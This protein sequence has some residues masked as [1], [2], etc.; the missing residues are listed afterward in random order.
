MSQPA[1]R[2]LPE[3]LTGFLRPAFL[4]RLVV[5]YIAVAALLMVCAP[6]LGAVVARGARNLILLTSA[7]P[8]LDTLTWTENH[9]RATTHLLGGHLSIDPQSLWFV[10][11]FPTG[12]AAA[13]PGLLSV[14][15]LARLLATIGI[16]AAVASFLLAITMDGLISAK[17]HSV[18]VQ[19]NPGWRDMLVRSAMGRFWD[20]AALMYPFLACLALAW[21]AVGRTLDPGGDS[22]LHWSNIAGVLALVLLLFAADRHAEELRVDNEVRLRPLLADLNPYYG[23]HLMMRAAKLERSGN[24]HVAAEACRA[25]KAYPRFEPEARACLGRIRAKL[26]KLEAGH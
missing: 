15:G 13:L 10:V 16:S 21:S 23:R 1:P 7:V 4:I 20:F 24:L 18:Y 12:F 11:V 6:I 14:R 9:F 3:L 22:L 5:A 19:V 26:D 8:Y 25:A 2:A 17:L